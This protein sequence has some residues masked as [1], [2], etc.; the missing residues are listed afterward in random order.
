MRAAV[1]SLFLVS[2]CCLAA[3]PAP[4]ASG[5]TPEPLAANS[6]FLPPGVSDAGPSANQGG[7]IELRGEMSTPKG[8]A[9]CIYDTTSKKAIWVL[10]GEQGNAFVV[11]SHDLRRDSVVVTYQGRTMGLELPAAKVA[12]S[13]TGNAPTLNT[14]SAAPNPDDAAKLAA[15]AAE[16]ARRRQMREQ[17]LQRGANGTGGLAPGQ[18]VQ[19][20]PQQVPSNGQPPLR[21]RQMQPPQ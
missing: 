19:P 14:I 4:A 11:K 9:F 1:L 15:I 3:A 2:A 8:L 20:G 10:E 21:R 13:G 18:P 17:E 16:V 5:P 12:S 6:P 7:A